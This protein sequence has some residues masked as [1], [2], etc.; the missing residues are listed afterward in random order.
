M[1][2]NY[3]PEVS[4]I[5]KLFSSTLFKLKWQKFV[6]VFFL[7]GFCFCESAS[8]V[9]TVYSASTGNF[10]SSATWS[11]VGIGGTTC[12]FS[13]ISTDS[14]VIGNGYTVT[15]DGNNAVQSLNV[16]SGG[17]VILGGG[18]GNN[19]LTVGNGGVGG[20]TV[21]GVIDDLGNNKG[22]LNITG[23]YMK[24]AGRIGYYGN[25]SE[26][27]LSRN[28]IIAAGS[29][30]TINSLVVGN[31]VNF[32]LNTYT[33]TNYG[34]I[35]FGTIIPFN[36]V[37]GGTLVNTSEGVMNFQDD[38]QSYTP[39]GTGTWPSSITLNATAVGN[40]INFQNAGTPGSITL[41]TNASLTSANWGNLSFAGTGTTYNLGATNLVTDN[42][43]INSG[44]FSTTFPLVMFG[45]GKSFTN[46]AGSFNGNTQTVLFAG[47]TTIAGAT[48]I[49]FYNVN[50]TGTLIGH[51][52]NYNVAGT[53]FA[54]S[55]T[56]THNSGT[57]TFTGSTTLSGAGMNTSTNAFNNVSITGTLI[58]ISNGNFYVA[59]TWSNNGVYTANAGTSNVTFNGA[60]AQ[61]ITGTVSTTFNTLTNSN[62]SGITLG[63]DTY[64]SGSGTLALGS[65]VVNCGI[66]NMIINSG[67]SVSRSTG[68]VNGALQKWFVTGGTARTFEI[69][70]AGNYDPVTLTFT[71]VTTAGYVSCKSVSGNDPSIN[72]SN[73]DPNKSVTNYWS[74]VNVGVSF[75]GSYSYAFTYPSS[76]LS[77][78][79][80]LA[81]LKVA[82]LTVATWTALPTPA[83]T[84]TNVLTTV[85]GLT[86]TTFGEYQI[87]ENFNPITIYNAATGSINWSD[88]TKWIQ[89]RT[90]TIST[91]ASGVTVT[92]VSTLFSTELKAGDVLLSQTTPG[93]ALGTI[94][95]IQSN[96]SLTLTAGGASSTLNNI[97]YGRQLVPSSSELPD[98]ASAQVSL[99]NPNLVPAS[100]TVTLDISKTIYNL[101]YITQGFA[102][103]I[104]HSGTNA[105][106][107]T[108]DVNINQ[109]SVGAINAWN[110]NGGTATVGGNVVLGSADA[111]GGRVS[112]AVLTTGTLNVTTDIVYNTS[113][114]ANA[115]LDISGGAAT[116]NLSG[117]MTLSSA[118]TLSPGTSSIF[119]YISSTVAQ[120]VTIGSSISYSTLQLSN[121]SSTGAQLGGNITTTNVTSTMNVLAGIFTNGGYAI[122]GNPGKSFNVSNG[123]TFEMTGA[124][125]LPSGFSV[126]SFGATSNT[127][128]HQNVNTTVLMTNVSG[129]GY[130]HLYVQPKANGLT[131]T[132]DNTTVLVAGNLYLGN[133]INSSE[134]VQGS[135][136]TVLTVTGNI[137]IYL[138]TIFYGSTIGTIN[139]GGD[140]TN[141]GTFSCGTKTVV[142]NGA[143]A[144]QTVYGPVITSFY[145]LTISKA[146]NNV[147]LSYPVTIAT[148]GTLTLTK[149]LLNTSSTNLLTMQATSIATSIA[150]SGSATSYVNGPMKK[151]GNTPFVF[152]LGKGGRWARLGITFNSGSPNATSEFIAEYFTGSAPNRTQK[153]AGVIRVSNVEYWDITRPVGASPADDVLLTLYWE[154]NSFSGINNPVSASLAVGHYNSGTSL[155]ESQG[156]GTVTGTTAGTIIATTVLPSYSPV[157]FIDNTGGS[158]PLPIN[159][160]D[161]SAVLNGPKVDLTWVTGSELN[162]NYF[163]IEKTINGTTFEEVKRV[164][165]AGNSSHV[166]NY[167]T[168]DPSP[169]EGLSYYRLKQTDYDGKF[170]YSK[171]VAVKNS[172][173][174]KN[175]EFKVFP[176]PSNGNDV[177]VTSESIN[178]I[179]KEVL[180]VL[181]NVLGEVVFSKVI[182]SDNGNFITAIDPAK[183]LI[184][185]VYVVVGSSNN[186][187]YR[188]ALL[189]K[190]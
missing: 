75:S 167:N 98:N 178:E 124:T 115:V 154:S 90:G 175:F 102:H 120:T 93:V 47:S 136:S 173:I 129:A 125:A 79:A 113:L 123:A 25:K 177:Y 164:A 14:V 174:K 5:K 29:N 135:A 119:N 33:L 104:T 58:G 3:Y 16:N 143:S 172:K 107:V 116:V 81:N 108:Q 43:T 183:K 99:G 156:H 128:Y 2:I 77:G 138:N 84:P 155:W 158:D 50:V 7:A 31:K 110:I 152:P 46:V 39:L 133:G 140:W 106:T 44:K 10:S 53:S 18:A 69:G 179:N 139:I 26:M 127:Q 21:D 13:P 41:P 70:N 117:S 141:N 12:G 49:T 85:S 35:T 27:Y 118:G 89:Y 73:F 169:Y 72:A 64:I 189:I 97:S 42:L 163:T 157:T 131:F 130:G 95:S 146:S 11:T 103:S 71:N 151:V 137:T 171:M 185:G 187:I 61:T 24:G 32:N 67:G 9:R 188:Q 57:V 132:F 186:E 48:P 62:T 59:G 182:V 145:N 111:T 147:T 190:E 30:L 153:T 55:G 134:A 15:N 63:I 51:T 76:Q 88:Q 80:T 65:N 74:A 170:V 4:S 37:N 91:V 142:F 121:T 38:F 181:Y 19:I 28:I 54:V 56:Y 23:F 112:K 176:N 161:F 101:T 109:P 1:T 86:A 162:N 82:Q 68:Y 122:A 180:V 17:I 159:L 20:L 6:F 160:I 92:G 45:S 144:L 78:S 105:L 184:P 22:F 96:T 149:G 148:S 40:T 168:I 165:G 87:G 8:A 166:I 114:A 83:P 52:S 100:V 36:Q 94:L 66:Y 150:T 34:T 126:L 60:S